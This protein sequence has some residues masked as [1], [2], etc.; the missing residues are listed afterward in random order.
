VADR[1]SDDAPVDTIMAGP[2]TQR[3]GSTRSTDVQVAVG[4]I[5]AELVLGWYTYDLA[6]SLTRHVD[7][8]RLVQWFFVM[9]PFLPLAVVVALHAIRPGR[10]LTALLGALGAGVVYVMQL[11]LVRWVFTHHPGLDPHVIEI[12]GYATALTAATLA[13]LAW[14]LSRRHGHAWPLGLLAAAGGAWL[15]LWTDWTTRVGWSRFASLSDSTGIRQAELLHT[16]AVMI[17]IVAACLVCWLI[18]VAELRRSA[19]GSAYD[20]GPP[21]P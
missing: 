14:G 12:V 10:A 4:L 20:E 17:P 1:E 11:E 16:I 6:R 18:D 9:L 8:I 21:P 19:T 13:A 7:A 3:Q 5:V 2:P 15:T